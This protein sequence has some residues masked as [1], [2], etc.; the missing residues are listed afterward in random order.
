MNISRILT[1]YNVICA[2]RFYCKICILRNFGNIIKN[3]V[4]KMLFV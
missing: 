2:N 3:L 1:Y 4:P